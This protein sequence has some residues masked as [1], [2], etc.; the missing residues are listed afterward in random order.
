MGKGTIIS[1]G[2]DGQ[3]QLQINYDRA[4]YTAE[5]AKLTTQISEWTTKI[6]DKNAE[7]II[8]ENEY[9]ALVAGEFLPEVLAAKKNKISTAEKE[10]ASLSIYK[11]SFE[12]RKQYLEENMPSDETVSV[13]CADFT[14]DLTGTVGTVEVPGESTNIQIQ[15]GYEGN[16]EYSGARDGVLTPIVVQT[17]AQAFYNLA[18]LP[19]WQKWKPLF[20]YATITAI[21]GDTASISLDNILSSQQALK[22]N[23]TDTLTGVTIDY[24]DCNGSAF[25]VGDEVLV[26]FIGQ[27]WES[28]VI[29]GFKEEPKACPEFYIKV[30]FNGNAPTIGSEKI[31]LEFPDDE[32]GDYEQSHILESGGIIGPFEKAA[33]PDDGVIPGTILSFFYT[34][35]GSTLQYFSYYYENTD[36]PDFYC[37]IN[38]EMLGFLSS[39]PGTYGTPTKTYKQVY[40]LKQDTDIFSFPTELIEIGGENKTAYVIDFE[41]KSMQEQNVSYI[42]RDDC[43]CTYTTTTGGDIDDIE[44]L[45]PIDITD[46]NS[47][48]AVSCEDGSGNVEEWDEDRSFSVSPSPASLSLVTDSGGNDASFTDFNIS[49]TYVYWWRVWG[50]C[51][52]ED[53]VLAQ[54]TN[55]FMGDRD[56]DIF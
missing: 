28:P 14:E 6:S 32:F 35:N 31:Y 26:K 53:T 43:A 22:I 2:T 37:W 42:T 29:V 45:Y 5:L 13:W 23:Q 55:Y 39:D 3:Y 38:S 20:R 4:A 48:G 41:V 44:S 1:G 8:L 34:K 30:T 25:S 21:S 12:K 10:K 40:R 7:I 17:A 27:S 47:S 19:G 52:T 56:S 9:T 51:E 36:D 11:L 18:M 15:P 49:E 33:N 24:M 50:V 16:A 54:S 46:Q